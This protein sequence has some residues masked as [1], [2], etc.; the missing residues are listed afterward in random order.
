[1]AWLRLAVLL[2]WYLAGGGIAL[3][4][5]ALGLIRLRDAFVRWGFGVF[6]RIARIKVHC[7]GALDSHRPLLLV[8]NH[9]SYMDIPILA[10]HASVGFTPKSRIA[11]WPVIGF[12]SRVLDC[13][14]IDRRVAKT[15]ENKKALEDKLGQGRAILLFAEGTTSDGKRVLPFRSAYFGIEEIDGQ[16]VWI[17]PASIRYVRLR[18]MPVDSQQMPRI[19][20]YGDMYLLPHILEFLALGPL[21]VKLCFFPAVRANDFDSR[22]TLAEYCYRLIVKEKESVIL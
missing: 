5:H 13:V 8:S 22:K 3:L 15:A 11:F 21:E 10:S 14:F 19:A 12:M 17:Q 18:G 16:P 4:L 9:L 7:T 2:S 6:L 20:W 1:M